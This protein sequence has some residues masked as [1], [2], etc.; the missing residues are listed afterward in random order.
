MEKRYR[1]MGSSWMVMG[2]QGKGE[3][4]KCDREVLKDNGKCLRDKALKGEPE[5]LKSD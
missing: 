5:A 2:R 4:L 1:A 3:A